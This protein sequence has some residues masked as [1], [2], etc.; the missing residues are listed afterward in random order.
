MKGCTSWSFEV[1]SNV[2]CSL[3]LW[4]CDHCRCAEVYGYVTAIDTTPLN[5]HNRASTEPKSQQ[6]WRERNSA[7]FS[8]R[9]LW[10]AYLPISHAP[11]YL[12]LKKANKQTNTM[13]VY[14]G[15]LAQL[16]LYLYWETSTQCSSLLTIVQPG[17]ST[18]IYCIS[19]LDWVSFQGKSVSVR[20]L[21]GTK[22]FTQRNIKM[23]R[24]TRISV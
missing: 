12:M 6:C 7:V 18:R 13:K 23:Y 3:M 5:F 8:F 22:A 24:G 2:G 10:K 17:R 16:Q 14:T 19:F 1:P 15:R 9:L 20:R 11:L 21:V 4:F